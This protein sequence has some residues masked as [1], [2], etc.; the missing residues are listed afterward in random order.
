VTSDCHLPNG[1]QRPVVGSALS[2]RVEPILAVQPDVILTQIEPRHFMPVTKIRPDLQI[3]HFKIETIDD[4]AAAI[5]RV[6]RIVDRPEDAVL[7]KKNFEETI[8]T[9]LQRGLDAEP[10]RVLFVMGHERPLSPGKG[11]FLD[12]MITLAGA[13]NI[14]ADQ[15]E[16]WRQPS[17]ESIIELEP[18]AIICQ[19][20]SNTE[21]EARQYWESLGADQFTRDVFVVTDA[22]WT[23]PAGHLADYTLKLQQMLHPQDDSREDA[24][25]E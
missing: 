16:G 12:E 24:A 1:E 7:A 15:F 4:I 25:G 10:R 21:S 17:V 23:L 14:L 5:E 13:T 20:S 18:D 9:A 22:D 19:A 8:E 2:V 11:T 3:E 6:G